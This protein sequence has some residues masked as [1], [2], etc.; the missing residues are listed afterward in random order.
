MEAIYRVCGL[1]PGPK[2]EVGPAAEKNSLPEK[3][4]CRG[5]GISWKAQKDNLTFTSTF[6]LKKDRISHNQKVQN[7]NFS[8]T[9]KYQLSINFLS[10]KKT[11]FP[12]PRKFLNKNFPVVS[13]YHISVKFLAQKDR[14][15]YPLKIQ[16][17]GSLAINKQY[18]T[19]K[20]IPCRRF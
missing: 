14:I 4:Y 3:T 5:P 18:S 9:S 11:V 7:K 13:K 1:L 20:K 10:Q 17:K 16:N 15:M 12:I 2:F 19:V 6:W 8:V